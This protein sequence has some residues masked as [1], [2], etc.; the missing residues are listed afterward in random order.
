MPTSGIARATGDRTLLYSNG[1]IWREQKKLVAPPFA[2][3]TLFQPEI[4]S[5]FEA[6]FRTI[7]A[8]RLE[9]IRRRVADSP[10]PTLRVQLEPEIKAAMLEMLVN[11]FF[12]ADVPTQAIR[13]RDVPALDTV[14][15]N[16]VKDTVMAKAGCPLHRLP[17]FLP[18]VRKARHASSIFEDLVTR[19]IEPRARRAGAWN[20]FESDA[21]DAALRPNIRVFLAGALEAT[22]SYASWALSHL[23]RHPAA[24]ERL[25]QEVRNVN[26][27]TPDGLK[28]LPYL[29]CV[30]NETLRLTPALYFHPR[31]P[32]LDTWV[33]TDQD[34]T[35]FL[36]AGT[37]V[38]LDVW[39]ANR[40][41]EFWGT[42]VTGAPAD[43]FVPE[44][45]WGKDATDQGTRDWLHFGF[46]HG[47]RFCP[48][49]NLGQIE[50]ALLVG[51][52][53]KLFTLTPA[54]PLNP[55]RAG[56]ST[57]PD[58]GVLVDLRI[59]SG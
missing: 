50:T 2:R 26:D 6:T 8:D 9:A 46:G 38:L 51:G 19:V 22:T 39:H 34:Q 16:I 11:S 10:N 42:A 24:Q 4:F 20:H 47:P 3:S 14:I 41:E 32:T 17:G 44:R 36:P 15:D 54:H 43:Q 23:A 35:L 21:P 18:G 55:A 45:W 59:R 57:K 31:R 5:G 53:I 1:A 29:S 48:G 28:Q 7:A 30:L 40:H 49:K 13:S 56:V 37:H 25:Y 12:G 58:D 27:Y 52:V 33:R